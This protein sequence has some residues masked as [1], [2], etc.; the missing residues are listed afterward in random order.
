MRAFALVTLMT[1]AAA[2]AAAQ[3][4]LRMATPIPDG[5]VWAREIRGLAREIEDRTHGQVRLKVYFSGIAGDELEVGE[6]IARDQ[7]DGAFS[8]GM[9]CMRLAPSM[10]VMRV[11]GLFQGREELS[12]V[13]GRLKQNIDDEFRKAGFV[14]LGL[15]GVGPELV[16]SRKPI[17]TLAQLKT[18]KLWIWSADNTLGPEL[19][20]LGFAMTP[21]PLPA[22]A[23]LYDDG[24]VDGFIAAPA[25][26]LAFQWSAQA[27]YLL[28]L[29]LA[30]LDACT[31]ISNRAFDPL[32]LEYQQ[33]IRQAS[34]RAIAHLDDAVAA[35]DQALLNGLFA[36]QGVHTTAVPPV[37]RAQFFDAAR[38]A[39]DKMDAAMIPPVLLD[40]VLSLLADFRAE[41]RAPGA[42]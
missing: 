9:L 40:R 31:I 18:A 32:P 27:H 5:T 6:R 41:H 35:Q 2:P 23:R 4:M 17:A 29:R 19:R 25:A 33:I 10:R 38:A 15:V 34:A 16:F 14:N 39:R 3:T 24:Q 37:L 30:S 1:L 21:A 7:L 36:R 20:R 28:P 13:L 11:L 42:D 8:G 26:A 12:Y 22:A